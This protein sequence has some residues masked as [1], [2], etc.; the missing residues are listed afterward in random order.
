MLTITDLS[1]N[2]ELSATRMGE[3]AGGV[4]IGGI[5]AIAAL[6]VS[7]AETIVDHLPPQVMR[8]QIPYPT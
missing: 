8:T 1:R 2:E 4:D 5:G 3:V 6:V 7:A